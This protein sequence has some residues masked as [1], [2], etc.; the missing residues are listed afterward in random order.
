[1]AAEQDI[2]ICVLCERARKTTTLP[3][4]SGLV[5]GLAQV[6]LG[7]S[8]GLD[9]LRAGNDNVIW[10]LGLASGEI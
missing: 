8:V 2:L 1:M 10:S 3:D 5:A 7:L 9:G 4:C 6:G